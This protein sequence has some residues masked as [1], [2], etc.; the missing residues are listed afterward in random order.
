MRESGRLLMM[1]IS[2]ENRMPDALAF[3]PEGHHVH[4]DPGDLFIRL[5]SQRY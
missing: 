2:S 3:L 4:P 5:F 1:H